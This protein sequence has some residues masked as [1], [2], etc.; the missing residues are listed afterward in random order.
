MLDLKA[1]LSKILQMLQISETITFTK[2]NKNWTFYKIGNVVYVYAPA[3]VSGSVP[4]GF[5]TIGTLSTSM[6]PSGNVYLGVT[7]AGT[8]DY[9]LTV[10]NAGVVRYYQPSATSSAHNA[11]FC[12]YSYIA[13]G[14][15]YLV[16]NLILSSL[17]RGWHYVRPQG[18]ATQ[19]TKF[20]YPYTSGDLELHNRRG[21]HLGK[22]W[23]LYNSNR[24]DISHTRWLQQFCGVWDRLFC[25]I[26]KL[27]LASDNYSRKRHGWVNRNSDLFL[28][29]HLYIVDK[30]YNCVKEQ[31]HIHYK[32]VNTIIP[33]R[34]WCVC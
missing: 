23:Q 25:H 29:R 4:A 12:G 28:K 3:D 5:S 11:G 6:R 30:M 17:L 14:G 1:L 15:G 24:G 32:I 27:H 22:I 18:V 16:S 19:N 9:R 26:I 8:L 21:E 2:F 31:Y 10:D 34:G 20:S 13:N 7:N 33:Q